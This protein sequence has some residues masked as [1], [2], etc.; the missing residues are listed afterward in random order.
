MAIDDQGRIC[1]A[2]E[3]NNRVQV[4][5]KNGGFA[6]TIGQLGVGVGESEQPLG[7]AVNDNGTLFVVDRDNGR[8]QRF[9]PI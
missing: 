3:R 7:I 9:D 2:E 8:V 5:T 1:V 6:R 4:L